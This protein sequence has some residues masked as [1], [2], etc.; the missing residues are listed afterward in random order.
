MTKILMKL[1]ADDVKGAYVPA[2]GHW[3]TEENPEATVNDFLRD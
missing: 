1:V 2:A 3:V